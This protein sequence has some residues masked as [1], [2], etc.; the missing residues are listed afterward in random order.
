MADQKCKAAGVR[1][2]EDYIGVTVVF[3]CHDGQG[4]FLLHRRSENCRDE[5]GRWDCGGGSME[6]GETF[7]QAVRREV[8]EEYCTDPIS[9]EFVAVDNIHRENNGKATHW[10]AAVHLVEVDPNQVDNGDPVKIEDLQWFEPDQFPK[11]QHSVLEHH[12]TFVK[13]HLNKKI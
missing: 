9:I 6:H 5:Q 8:I 11:P 13:N 1:R 10:V 2:G 7:D 12:F 3:Y 4:R